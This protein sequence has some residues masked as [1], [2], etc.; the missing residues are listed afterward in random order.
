MRW[1]MALILTFQAPVTATAAPTVVTLQFDDGNADTYAAL[2]IMR[3]RGAR[4]TF[5]VNTGPLGDATHLSW[6]Q[7][8]E[9]AA[10]GNEITGHTVDHVNVKK[11]KTDALR[12]QICD[13]R[14]ALVARGYPA[15]SFAYPFGGIDAAAKQMVASCGYTTGRSVSGVNGR[16]VFAETVP[17]LDAYATR[18]PPN[19][20]SSTT[21]AEIQGYVTAAEQNGG[22]WVQLVI[23]HLCD[24]CDPYSM[25]VADFTAL[26]DWLAARGS[27]VRTTAEVMS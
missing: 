15:V 23:H 11:L 14:A 1:L 6:A 27:V 26:V 19:V 5:Y 7:L 8:A 18:T 25:T 16:S 3:D 2:A 10:A 9:L 12:H 17:P 4:A 22:G 13:D 24:H 20:K 21:L